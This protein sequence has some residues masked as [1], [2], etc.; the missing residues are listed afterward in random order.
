MAAEENL[1]QAQFPG[2][3]TANAQPEIV[4]PSWMG[5]GIYGG[6]RGQY[7]NYLAGNLTQISGDGNAGMGLELPGTYPSPGQG[8][9]GESSN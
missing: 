3:N 2:F 1:S 8:V 4:G 7:G 5:L 6:P 9:S